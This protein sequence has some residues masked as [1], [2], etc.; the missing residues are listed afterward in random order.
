ML[1]VFTDGSC[2]GG[3]PGNVGAGY[4]LMRGGRLLGG[5]GFPCGR[6]TNNQGELAAV[7]AGLDAGMGKLAQGEDVL[8]VSDSQY[9]LYG[10][11]DIRKRCRSGVPNNDLWAEIRK[12]LDSLA[13]NGSKCLAYWVRGHTS[14][15]GNKLCDKLANSAATYNRRFR[16][17][18]KVYN[19]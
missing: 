18:Q 17:Q 6:G 4:I 12:R 7:I 11:F 9:M 10:L 5:E 8:L 3:N 1:T 19:E 16:P 15:S 13:A 2:V 14:I